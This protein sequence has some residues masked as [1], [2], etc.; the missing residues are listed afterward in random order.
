MP[1]VN[2][3]SGICLIRGLTTYTYSLPGTNYSHALPNKNNEGKYLLGHDIVNLCA[4]KA[5]ILVNLCL[6]LFVHLGQREERHHGQDDQREA[7]EPGAQVRQTPQ[8][9]AKLV[10]RSSSSSYKQGV[11]RH[12]LS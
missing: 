1:F 2:P 7:V 8:Q 6:V 11:P 3:A 12:L 5:D 4:N 9:A 10:G